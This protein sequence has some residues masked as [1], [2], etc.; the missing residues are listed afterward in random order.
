MCDWKRV[1]A[2][3]KSAHSLELKYPKHL[4]LG[5]MTQM[6]S[7]RS[8]STFWTRGSR[9]LLVSSRSL[10]WLLPVPG[11][12]GFTQEVVE[13]EIWARGYRLL[14]GQYI[15]DFLMGTLIGWS[16]SLHLPRV[17]QSNVV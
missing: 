4:T 8:R 15:V 2:G 11:L 16:I 14:Q 10:F 6:S 3:N 13:H 1:S 9:R 12:G 7:Q 17:R 5:A